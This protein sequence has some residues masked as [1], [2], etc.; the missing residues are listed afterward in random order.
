MKY[1]FII[2][3]YN[4]PSLYTTLMSFSHFYSSRSDYEILILED[5]KTVNDLEQ[6]AILLEI[7]QAHSSL[8]IVHMEM[9]YD[10]YSCPYSTM[11]HGVDVA[12]GEFVFLTGPEI[13]HLVDVLKG[14]D[15]EFAKDKTTYINCSC[16]LN[17]VDDRLQ[18]ME[19]HLPPTHPY[20]VKWYQ[21]TECANRMLNFSTCMS[22]ENFIS[23]NGFN[24]NYDAGIGRGDVDFAKRARLNGIEFIC[25]DDLVTCHIA[26][27]PSFTGKPLCSAAASV[28]TFKSRFEGR[29]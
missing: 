21:H 29:K 18:S 6:H 28:K 15:E 16:F 26:H 11:N 20:S 8:P 19:G 12:K 13:M 4:R 24:E 14:L 10:N 17:K 1:S 7:L 3:Y 5:K 9:N 25:R 2:P 23:M 27:T 22:K